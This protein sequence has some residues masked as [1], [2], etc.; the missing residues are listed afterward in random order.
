VTKPADTDKTT[1][2]PTTVNRPGLLDGVAPAIKPASPGDGPVTL[3]PDGAGITDPASR[4]RNQGVGGTL[5]F[6]RAPVR[7]SLGG[8]LDGP[9]L[10]F[11]LRGD[12]LATTSSTSASLRVA[13]SG[14][15]EGLQGKDGEVDVRVVLQAIE[16]TGVALSVGAVWWATRAG[17]LVASLLMS[18]PAWRSFDPLMVLGPEDEDDRDWARAIDDQAAQDEMGIA[19][20]F[21]TR[22]GAQP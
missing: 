10:D 7:L 1:K 21:D 18:A 8:G 19:D 11:M 9:L 4:M 3:A 6:E 2:A 20:V 13:E 15:R 22:T 12:S 5:R 17:A 14:L 16:L